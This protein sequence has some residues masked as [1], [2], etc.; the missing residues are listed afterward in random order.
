MRLL[1]MSLP[2]G[3]AVNAGKKAPVYLSKE[4]G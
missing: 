3:H 4:K 2:K 1:D